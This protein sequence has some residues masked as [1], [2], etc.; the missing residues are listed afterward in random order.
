MR[1]GFDGEKR[2]MKGETGG[3]ADEINDY[4]DSKAARGGTPEWVESGL[5]DKGSGWLWSGWVR[6]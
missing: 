6:P 5:D 1:R 2:R 4:A 3:A